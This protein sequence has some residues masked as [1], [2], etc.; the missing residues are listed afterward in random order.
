MISKILKTNGAKFVPVIWDRSLDN[1][2][3]WDPSVV[4]SHFS[5]NSRVETPEI[6]KFYSIETVV[7]EMQLEKKSDIEDICGRAGLSY[8]L[9]TKCRGLKYGYDNKK[10]HFQRVSYE[11]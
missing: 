2:N 8:L 7:E 4:K 5:D 3:Q 10:G 11:L 9:Y 1:K 6:N